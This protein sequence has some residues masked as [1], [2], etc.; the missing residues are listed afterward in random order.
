METKKVIIKKKGKRANIKRPKNKNKNKASGVYTK[1][2]QRVVYAAKQGEVRRPQGLRNFISMLTNLHTSNSVAHFPGFAFTPRFINFKKAIY[3]LTVNS[4][5]NCYFCMIP[6]LFA[7]NGTDSTSAIAG[8]LSVNNT[9]YISVDKTD[10]NL[11]GTDATNLAFSNIGPGPS[12]A[13]E[14]STTIAANIGITVTGVAPIYRKGLLT[15]VEDT[16]DNY[17]TNTNSASS[18]SFNN[19]LNARPRSFMVKNP[20]MKEF[21]LSQNSDSHLYRFI[22]NF[23]SQQFNNVT[24]SVTLNPSL[25]G[26]SGHPMKMLHIW[27]SGC[28]A[29][30]TLRLTV[31]IA[32]SSTIMD[33]FIDTYPAQYPTS[34]Q[35]PIVYLQKMSQDKDLILSSTST[36]TIHSELVVHNSVKEI[37]K[38]VPIVIRDNFSSHSNFN[39]SLGPYLNESGILINNTGNRR[40]RF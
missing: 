20:I 15:I 40:R 38:E 36:N 33:Q 3:D 7:M 17:I 8:L 22:P 37:I 32:Y 5:G 18:S 6:T 35:D 19:W 10:Y 13:F 27:M 4:S 39:D 26:L 31:N 1:Q 25:T 14:T 29:N 11:T 2:E 23:G 28:E 34:F 12:T 21:D 24:R 30:T 16:D 9:G